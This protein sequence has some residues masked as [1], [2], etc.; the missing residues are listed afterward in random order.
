MYINHNAYL[1]IDYWNND[2]IY[3]LIDEL[4][5]DSKTYHLSFTI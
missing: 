3:Q 1:N 4:E 2:L 5:L